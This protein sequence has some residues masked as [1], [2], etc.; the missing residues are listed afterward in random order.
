MNNLRE[1]LEALEVATRNYEEL[2]EKGAT[3]KELRSA[4]AEVKAAKEAVDLEQ[5]VRANQITVLDN[6]EVPEER[7]GEETKYE[8][9][10]LR[11]LRGKETKEDRDF[12]ENRTKNVP[13]ATPYLQSA[14]DA[15]G[16]LI[17]PKDVQTKINEYK[18]T[19]MFDLTTLIDVETTSFTSGTRVYEKLSAQTPFAN[20]DEW[21]NI[22]DIKSPQFEQKAYTMK[23]YAGILPVPRQ[24]LQDTDQNLLTFLAKYIAK[25]SVF[26]RNTQVLNVL[27]AITKRTAV[28]SGADDIKDILNVELDG[29][30]SKGAVLLTNQDGFN[31]LDKLKDNDGKYLLQPDVVE[32]TGYVFSNRKI[33]PLP[34][35]ILPSTGTKAPLFVGDFKEAIKMFKRGVYEVAA[36]EVGGDSFRRNSHDIR[37]IDRFDIQSWDSAAV[38]SADIETKPAAKGK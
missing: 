23:T 28:V 16:G 26:T 31:Y 4:V 36:T 21:D 13:N 32:G 8:D 34:N 22:E 25:K 35:S 3:M 30:F 33:I 24:L 1:L 18:R 29:V 10:F 37:V 2:K 5:E 17:I 15:D 19:E 14:V 11:A 38:I 20:I 7:A 27:K 9:V 6:A 12:L